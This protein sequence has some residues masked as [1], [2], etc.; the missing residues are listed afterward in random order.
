M[1]F[2][3]Y[4]RFII[5]VFEVVSYLILPR[6]VAEA[7]LSLVYYREIRFT[8]KSNYHSVIFYELLEDNS[9]FY[10]FPFNTCNA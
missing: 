7:E 6:L 4:D 9:A 5:W 3:G 10:D 2:T 1:K 8:S